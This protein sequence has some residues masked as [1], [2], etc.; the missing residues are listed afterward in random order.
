[1]LSKMRNQRSVRSK[2]I[3]E[4]C[5]MSVYTNLKIIHPNEPN[6]KLSDYHRWNHQS[7]S[8]LWPPNTH[9]TRQGNQKE[10][11]SPQ[12][13]PKDTLPPSYGQTPPTFW[14]SQGFFFVNGSPF[15]HKKPGKIY[16]RSVQ[17]CNNRGKSE[18]ISV[19]NKVKTKYKDRGFTIT[20]YHG[21]NEYNNLYNF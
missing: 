1:M 17:A 8:H 20:Y 7:R 3:T 19:L 6:Q 13:H 14:A 10:P 9:H 4:T 18:T 12:Y 11:R 2:N 15:L 16:F 21:D 5:R